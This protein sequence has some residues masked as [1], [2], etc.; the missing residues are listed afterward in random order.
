MKTIKLKIM[1][2]MMIAGLGPLSPEKL[3][4]QPAP[5]AYRITDGLFRNHV[6]YHQLTIPKGKETVLA[7]LPGPGKVTYFYITDDSPARF[8]PGLVLKIFWDKETEPSVLVPLSDFFGSFGQR[9]IEFQSAFIMVNHECYMSYWPMPFSTRARFILANDGDRDYSQAVAYGIDYEQDSSFANERSRFCCAWHRSNPVTNGLHTILDVQGRGHYL[10]NFLEVH[11]EFNG[12]WG[13]GDTIFHSDGQT[14]THTPGTEDEYGSC[15]GFGHTYSYLESGCL[16]MGKDNRMY[17]WYV[18]NPVRFR[19]SLKVEIQNEHQ[20]GP[21]TPADADDY[22][23]VA[24]WYQEAPHKSLTLPSFAER[25]APTR[26]LRDGADVRLQ[27]KVK[28]AAEQAS[29]QDIVQN[30]AE[31]AGLKYDWQKS[32]AQTDPLC[33]QWVRNV[34]IDGQTCQQALDQILKPVGLRY[35]V[36]NGV[37]VLSRQ[38]E[39][40]HPPQSGASSAISP[41][42]GKGYV[43][44]EDYPKD[45]VPAKELSAQQRQENFEFL[46]DAID[47]TYACFDL[48]RIAWGEVCQRYRGQLGQTKTADD[49]YRLLFQ[50]VAELKDTHSWLQNFN[51]ALPSSGPGLTVELFDGRPFVVAVKP[52]SEAADAGIGPGAEILNIDGQTV[53]ERM[54]ALRKQLPG[55]STQRAFQREATRYLLAGD[56]GTTVL[57]SLRS[58]GASTNQAC[59]LKRTEGLGA[60]PHRTYAF[61]LTRQRFVDFGRHPSGAGYIRIES[62]NGRQEIATEFDRALEALKDTPALIL[63]VRGNPGGFGDAQPHIVGR[64]ITN[65]TLV[66]ISYRKNGPAH[67]DLD[68]QQNF[69]D[70]AG[71]W[72]YTHPMALL[73]DGETG[74]AA[75][76]FTC[77]MRSTGRVLTVGSPTHG[78]LSGVAAYAVLPCGL[79][80]RISNGYICD[81]TGKPIE[82]VGN[83]PDVPVSPSISDFL[84]GRDPVLERAAALLG[85]KLHGMG[86]TRGEQ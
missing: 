48:K 11:T 51:V 14:Q 33:R 12:W 50:L 84:A 45:M 1:I 72:Q 34:T 54:D 69:F 22:T 27:S 25:T 6:E 5:E 71:E 56:K 8:Y 38:D 47:K 58:P 36:E 59:S 80:V 66:A 39:G 20:N 49:F 78:N 16:E 7:D 83:E 26:T 23:T 73:I 60:M 24:F 37:L 29:V 10:G 52:G 85:E 40:T 76:L 63:D 68:R 21:T 82:G 53:Q 79:I 81:A 13:E 74:S 35:Q 44:T 18:A 62:F 61:E 42:I 46:C 3:V 43:T 31:Q 19:H 64:F 15:W 30:L 9:P 32:F 4:A 57:V 70:P 67:R 77:Y 17:R 86:V 55:R 65:K 28:Y 2:S 41:P 75:D